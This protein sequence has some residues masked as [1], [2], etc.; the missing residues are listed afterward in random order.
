VIVGV[1]VAL[2]KAK[3]ER[4]R[5]AAVRSR[6]ERSAS[7]LLGEAR[8]AGL[9]RIVVGQLELAIELLEADGAGNDEATVHE[10]R[11][12][13]KRVR[14]IVRLLRGELGE[15]RFARENDA[16]RECA[17]RVAGARDAEVMV[18][19]LDALLRREPQLWTAGSAPGGRGGASA[20]GARTGSGVE[21][22]RAQLVRE[23]ETAATA[24]RDAELRRAV[25]ADLRAIR[26]R[27]A[28]WELRERRGRPERLLTVGVERVY[29]EGRGRM[30]RARRRGDFESMHAWR[31]R[32]KAL[33]YAAETLD[34]G[35]TARKTKS[36]RRL[37]RVAR[38]ADRIGEM[39]GEE[40]DLALL[41]R[42]VRERAVLFAGER[43][44]RKRLLK[45]I[46]R[47]RKR[48]RKRA[49]REGERLY[50]RKPKAF[51]RGLRNAL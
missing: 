6:R 48:L 42:V 37:R 24:G 40:H 41:A 4:E 16:L 21:A 11:K 10:L 1:G 30:R 29:G 51:V 17:A 26:S 44:R 9:R 35:P 47:R 49:L 27:A 20:D 23:R 7:L 43:K 22:L 31:K 18:G 25:V 15:K 34:R 12:L 45:A 33:R 36:G 13:V 3:A 38:R 8:A 19:T 46:A 32:V 28:T 39:L 2:A 14:A 50:R 5:R